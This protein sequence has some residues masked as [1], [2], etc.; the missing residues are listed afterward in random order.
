MECSVFAIY[1]V[2]AETY[3]QILVFP[4]EALAIRSFKN[5]VNS[6][7]SIMNGNAEDFSLFLVGHWDYVTGKLSGCDHVEVC[8]GIDVVVKER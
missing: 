5:S 2:K 6:A 1:D 4:Q 8:K 3:S 7:E